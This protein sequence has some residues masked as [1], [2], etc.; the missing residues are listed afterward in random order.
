MAFAAI[1][2]PFPGQPARAQETIATSAK[3]AFLLDVDSNTVLLNVHGDELMHPA[4]MAKLMTM[5]V[6]FNAIKTGKLSLGDEFVVTEDAWR[7]GGAT[8]GGS[9]M[10][11]K[12]NSQIRL[13]DLIR[14]VI[15]QSGNDAC[16]I[17][18]EGMA[19]T[20]E[21]FANVMTQ[22]AREIGL[23]K[24]VFK[25]ATGLPDPEQ[26]VTARELAMLARHIIEAYPEFYPIYSEPD[27]EWNKIRQRNRNPLLS[28]NIGADG[29]KTGYTA[30]SGYG[31]VGSAVQDGRRLIVVVNGLES[32]RERATEA[33]KLLLWGFRAFEEIT[34]FGDGE[35]VGEVG[36]YGGEKSTVA[37]TGEG[38]LKLLIP[39][40]VKRGLKARIVYTGPLAAPVEK[41]DRVG[42]L[43][44]YNDDDPI[45][46]APL[47]ARESVGVGPI[48]K[49]ALDAALELVLGVF[50]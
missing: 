16:I 7:R 18:A 1:F 50:H 10:F 4:S 49:R 32:A 45:S 23:K 22:R 26:L 39:K 21:V 28:M 44:I 29:M 9:T 47:Y 43:R 8:S 13:E 5:E 15:V 42:V 14:G 11:A 48:H 33:Q 19:G 35:T 25:N 30:E 31:L 46:D 40:G 27:F 37:L 41:G 36:V 20:E 34:L 12:L 17:I 6:V 3:H 24:S 2:A 38:P